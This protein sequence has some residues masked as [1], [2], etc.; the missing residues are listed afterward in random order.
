MSRETICDICHRVAKK[1]TAIKGI[2]EKKY[3]WF[4]KNPWNFFEHEEIDICR[5]CCEEIKRKVRNASC[6]E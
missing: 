2:E 5:D 3:S 1:Y 6:G 4:I